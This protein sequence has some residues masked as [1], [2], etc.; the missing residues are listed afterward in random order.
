MEN[1]MNDLVYYRRPTHFEIE[2]KEQPV[3]YCH[4]CHK[5]IYIHEKVQKKYMYPNLRGDIF[6]HIFCSKCADKGNCFYRIDN[7]PNKSIKYMNIV[8]IHNNLGNIA[9]INIFKE[10]DDF[11]KWISQKKMGD[12]GYDWLKK[13]GYI[14]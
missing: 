13:K 7:E 11:V 4:K 9:G 10:F 6:I 2:N 1:N 5:G 8:D 14:V 12:E 3:L